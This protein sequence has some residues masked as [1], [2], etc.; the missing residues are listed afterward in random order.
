RRPTRLPPRTLPAGSIRRVGGEPARRTTARKCYVFL[1]GA[2]RR[3]RLTGHDARGST[4]R[5]HPA[6]LPRVSSG[7]HVPR[8]LR[9]EYHVPG[10]RTPVRARTRLFSGCDVRELR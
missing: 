9:N 8:P 3:R 6:A 4:S 5:H 7:G 1:A 10:V 2:E